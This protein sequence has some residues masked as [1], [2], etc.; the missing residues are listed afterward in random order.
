MRA[1]PHGALTRHGYHV[2]ALAHL[3]H[4]RPTDSRAFLAGG[5]PPSSTQE[6]QQELL[7]SGLPL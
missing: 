2:K 4:V 3:L 6:L 1:R 7:A 5:L